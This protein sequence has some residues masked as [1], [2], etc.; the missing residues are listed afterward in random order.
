MAMMGKCF[1]HWQWLT[2]FFIVIFALGLSSCVHR[3][4]SDGESE[5]WSR[6]VNGLSA[7]LK[8]KVVSEK[9]KVQDSYKGARIIH[10]IVCL[11]NSSKVSVKFLSSIYYAGRFDIKPQGKSA[12]FSR[13]GPAGVKVVTIAPGDIYE[14]DAYDYGYGI[15]LDTG[16]YLFNTFSVQMLLKPGKYSVDYTLDFS[17]KLLRKRLES[18]DWIKE[19]PEN[20]W[21]GVIKLENVPLFLE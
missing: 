19:S 8:F 4:V 9:F 21:S 10:P 18:Y 20:I 11:K 3:N 6:P 12:M 14:L 16:Y 7:A 17:E 1:R 2:V 13:S 15:G 5:K